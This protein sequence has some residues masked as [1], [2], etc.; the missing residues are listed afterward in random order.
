MSRVQT[1]GHWLYSWRH[2]LVY[3]VVTAVFVYTVRSVT[4]LRAYDVQAARDSAEALR[5]SAVRSCESGNDRTVVLRDFVLSALREPDPRQ[6]DFIADP[7][8]R[9]ALIEQ[10]RAS[11]TEMRDRA[12]RTFIPR[13]CGAE[14]PAPP[15]PPDHN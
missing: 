13:D 14:Y 12:V 1:L 4:E 10:A 11:R 6:F 2:A 15:P 3:L 9:A 7:D 8:Q 5:I